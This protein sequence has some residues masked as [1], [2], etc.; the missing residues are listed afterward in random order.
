MTTW[1]LVLITTKTWRIFSPLFLFL[2]S[3]KDW[4]QWCWVAKWWWVAKG[5]ASNSWC[6]TKHHTSLAIGEGLSKIKPDIKK[7]KTHFNPNYS[8]RHSVSGLIPQL[9]TVSTNTFV[10]FGSQRT[11]IS[12]PD[13]WLEAMQCCTTSWTFTEEDHVGRVWVCVQSGDICKA[14]RKAT[15]PHAAIR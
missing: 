5:E 10:P 2:T 3:H 9:F 4:K 7:P 8:F 13:S 11:N 14:K 6:I 1:K 12:L 15:P